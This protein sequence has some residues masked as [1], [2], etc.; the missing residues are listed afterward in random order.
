MSA[1][2]QSVPFIR[3]PSYL[4]K[5][6]ASPWANAADFPYNSRDLT[7]GESTGICTFRRVF[8]V[9]KGLK[10]ASVTATAL[11]LYDI[12]CNGVRVGEDELK[13]GWT[14]YTVRALED[15]F[16]L[17]PYLSE[18][19]NAL[20]IEVSNGWW[21][22]RISFGRYGYK[23]TALCCRITLDYGERCDRIDTDP[24]WQVTT[25]GPIRT[26][27]IWDGCYYDARRPQ[28]IRGEGDGWES[29]V[30]AE[31]FCA[32]DTRIGPPVRVQTALSR[33]PRTSTLYAGVEDD[34]TERGAIR[35]LRRAFG[36]GCEK[37]FL[38][39]GQILQLDLGQNCVGRPCLSFD[40]PKDATVILR[41]AEMCNDSGDPDHHG[42]GPKGSAYLENYRSAAS[43]LVYRAS[44]EEVRDF[45]PKHTF[46]GCRYLELTCDHPLTLT[47]LTF[48][49]LCSDI[50]PAG[51]FS[52]SNAEINQLFSNIQWGLRS[53]YIS[54]PTD[55][56]QRDERLGW[57][58]DTQ[59]F[60]G[61][62]MYLAN[63]HTFLAE[64]LRTARDSQREDGSYQDVIPDVLMY[65]PGAAAGW[66]DAGI[67]VPWR[68]YTVYKDKT[69]LREHFDS[70]ERY[71]AC[72]DALGGPRPT[73]GD[74]LNYE[75]TDS[76]YVADCYY[77]YDA[78]LM[79]KIASVLAKD[80]SAPRYAARAAHYR[81]LRAAL[82]EKFAEKYIADGDLTV[83]TQSSYLL[84]LYFGTV[85]ASLRPT[86]IRKLEDK[87]VQNNYTLSTGFLGTGILCQTLSEVGLDHLCYSLL[88]QTA[89]PSWLYSVRQGA[90]TVWER[91]NS[92]TKENGF[93]N[94]AMNSF[95]HYA[96]GV[97][98]EWLFARMAGIAPDESHP[99]FE[100]FL[101][102]PTPD[103]RTP[104]QIPAGQD[105]IT[106]AKASYRSPCG[107]IESE[108]EWHDEIF[109][110]RCTVP[111]GTTAHVALPIMK[112]CATFTL[113]S[114]TVPLNQLGKV[115]GGRLHFDLSAG[116]YTVTIN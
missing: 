19:E 48:E 54:I 22:S 61:A 92:Y 106:H 50:T 115:E 62:A 81:A 109:V 13:P 20:A 71:M 34:G 35:V 43:Q 84:A 89:D 55:C 10:K 86:L 16:D 96:Y 40:A 11:G 24:S 45:S 67:I 38:R 72:L 60:C 113:N 69:L 30:L 49:V 103:L 116:Q 99:G 51:D 29:A 1:I 23:P 27:D 98:A 56:P 101:L 91:W 105:R 58:G 36:D 100:E 63:V 12:F 7:L 79:E 82:T 87:I 97:I 33:S 25:D 102:Q 28:V 80:S 88:L 5:A 112:E 14:D 93:G 68:L 2:L 78:T 114:I 110:W 53:N 108:W 8:T 83:R 77:I 32:V 70:M 74:W 59:V 3:H 111:E 37:T 52:C 65:N 85:P 21:S 73:Y 6:S 4:P 44:G 41:F 15:T 26:A 107:L 64:W 18:G 46:Y 31:D 39:P 47:A 95:N 66:G 75:V 104:E 94:V 90:T 76:R 9:K 42:D 17:T 57:T